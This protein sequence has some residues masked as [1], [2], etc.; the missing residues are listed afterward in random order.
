M[1]IINSNEEFTL[2]NTYSGDLTIMQ[3]ASFI[4]RGILTGSLLVKGSANIYGI[5]NG[6]IEISSTGSVSVYGIVNGNIVS[7]SN[8]STVLGIVN[9]TISPNITVV[10]G[11]IIDGHIAD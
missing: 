11:A 8:D 1:Q 10:K 4:L 9:G 5:V 3:D 7:D 6:N 2:T